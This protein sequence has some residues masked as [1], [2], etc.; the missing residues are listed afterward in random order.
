MGIVRTYQVTC[1]FYS[2]F[3]HEIWRL[4]SKFDFPCATW[5]YTIADSTKGF[6]LGEL[7]FFF[8]WSE[9]R[10]LNGILSF[11]QN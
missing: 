1:A 7:F 6:L 8:F 4:I 2:I 10:T 5:P 9:H 3:F 11:N